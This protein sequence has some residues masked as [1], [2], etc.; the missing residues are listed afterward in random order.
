MGHRRWWPCSPAAPES[1]PR[2]FQTRTRSAS[3]LFSSLMATNTYSLSLSGQ[4]P[5]GG[6]VPWGK[7]WTRGLTGAG[8]CR[9]PRQTDFCFFSAGSLMKLSG[10]AMFI[11]C[12][13]LPGLCLTTT[14]LDSWGLRKTPVHLSVMSPTSYRWY[15]EGPHEVP[16]LEPTNSA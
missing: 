7:G 9:F 13:S 1:A 10:R 11:L 8:V 14:Q 5:R 15:R 16:Q 6:R 12:E 2:L 4:A 3:Q